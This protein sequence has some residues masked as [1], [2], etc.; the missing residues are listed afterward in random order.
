MNTYYFPLLQSTYRFLVAAMSKDKY[1][2]SWCLPFL[3]TR[4]YWHG[5]K[6]KA[7]SGSLSFDNFFVLKIR[8]LKSCHYRM[9]DPIDIAVVKV[10]CFCTKKELS[11]FPGIWLQQQAKPNRY[12]ALKLCFGAIMHFGGVFLSACNIILKLDLLKPG[13]S[14]IIFS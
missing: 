2:V 5:K 8:Y 7:A 10:A 11:I 6:V 1:Q 4:N 14:F 9:L 12:L 3:H 13:M